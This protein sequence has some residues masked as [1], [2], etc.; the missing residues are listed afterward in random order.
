MILRSIQTDFKFPMS[1]PDRVSVYHKLR[2]PPSASTDSFMLDVLILSEKHQRA[3]AR[4]VED[5]VV[6]DYRRGQKTSLQPFMVEQFSQTWRAQEEVKRLNSSK[7]SELM[8]R[9]RRLENES[10]DKEGAIEDVG[11][12]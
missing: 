3:A 6:Y 7:A 12:A 4:C 1:W 11:G 8:E 2:R 5:I 10:W 9:V